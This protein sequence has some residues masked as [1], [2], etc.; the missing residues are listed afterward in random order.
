MKQHI[1]VKSNHTH[2]I[3]G[4][5]D[6]E[7]SFVTLDSWRKCAGSRESREACHDNRRT[8]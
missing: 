1:P 8:S 6:F 5:R 2:E 3:K 7:V 4:H